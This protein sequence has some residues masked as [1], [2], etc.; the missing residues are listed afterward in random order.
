MTVTRGEMPTSEEGA[1]RLPS[2]TAIVMD[3]ETRRTPSE[4]TAALDRT[5]SGEHGRLLRRQFVH[6]AA[7]AEVLILESEKITTDRWRFSFEIPRGHVANG[8]PVSKRVPLLLGLELV[9]QS[10]IA[11]AHFA[12]SVPLDWRFLLRSIAFSW[13][14][15]APA[16]PLFEPFRGTLDVTL[17]TRRFRRGAVSGLSADLRLT[18]RGT[19][20]ASGSGDIDFVTPKTYRVVRRAPSGPRVRS[21]DPPL[22]DTEVVSNVLTARLGI[23]TDDPFVFD[24]DSDHVPGMLLAKVAVL[25]HATVIPGGSCAG[26][27]LR[28]HR[29]A[30]LDRTVRVSTRQDHRGFSTTRFTQDGGLVAEASC[31]SVV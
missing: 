4:D 27:S 29:F 17:T 3:G 31:H 13:D 30:E 24:H 15:T 12:E 21:A 6:K 10:G 8:Y 5:P 18:S 7:A 23:D 2:A 14:A 11:V 9:R 1:R 20:I 26:I 25:A 28:C 22:L 16:Y 19:Q